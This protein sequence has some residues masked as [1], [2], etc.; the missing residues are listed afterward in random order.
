MP[1]W[2]KRNPIKDFLRRNRAELFS[3]G[4]PVDLLD[5]ANKFMYFAEHGYDNGGDGYAASGLIHIQ[6]LSPDNRK[7]LADLVAHEFGESYRLWLDP[8]CLRR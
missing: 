6:G 4:V 3:C 1:N 5:D 8:E 7:K 2:K